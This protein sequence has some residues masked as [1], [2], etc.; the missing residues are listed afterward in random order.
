MADFEK[1]RKIQAD[2]I[3][4]S[5]FDRIS[6]VYQEIRTSPDLQRISGLSNVLRTQIDSIKW[7]A[8]KYR[9]ELYGDKLAVTHNVDQI[10]AKFKEIFSEG[11]I[12]SKPAKLLSNQAKDEIQISDGISLLPC[13]VDE[14]KPV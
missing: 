6:E 7:I 5:I 1:A 4:Q 9:P 10:S 12:S 3:V 14:S 8:C 2:Y 13:N 11:R